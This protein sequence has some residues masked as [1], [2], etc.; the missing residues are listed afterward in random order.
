M[1]SLNM[2]CDDIRGYNHLLVYN[3]FNPYF[4][5]TEYVIC[6]MLQYYIYYILPNLA[7]LLSLSLSTLSTSSPKSSR[8]YCNYISSTTTLSLNM[9]M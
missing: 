1:P 6:Y 8:G 7:P 5:N 2:S 9:S 4:H 3:K